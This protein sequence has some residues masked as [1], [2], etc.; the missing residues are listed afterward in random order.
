MPTNF[1]IHLEF[2][3][4]WRTDG[5]DVNCAHGGVKKASGGCFC[6][7]PF[8]GS[9][10]EEVDPALGKHALYLFVLG[11][12]V[13]LYILL[14]MGKKKM[15]CQTTRPLDNSDNSDNPTVETTRL[16]GQWSSCL[17]CWA[18]RTVEL[19]E[20]SSCPTDELSE[21]L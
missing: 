2:T 11:K 18:V 6:V 19:S 8:T 1:V 3:F 20:R 16:F 9:S 5:M 7:E 4:S 21:H 17:N 14:S 10:C 15:G 12:R 13:E